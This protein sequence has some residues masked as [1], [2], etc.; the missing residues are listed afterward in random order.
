MVGRRGIAFEAI[1]GCR[2]CG[3]IAELSG[4]ADALMRRAEQAVADNDLR[5]ACHLADL[6]GWAAPS[7]PAIHAASGGLH[8]TSQGRA[9]PHEQGDLHGCAR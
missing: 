1:T 7:D 8:R 6:A 4:G 3:A 2:R 9:E 5:L